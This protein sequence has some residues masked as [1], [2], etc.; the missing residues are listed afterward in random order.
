MEVQPKAQP[1]VA[2]LL[3]F[4]KFLYQQ[5][6]SKKKYL[7]KN[8]EGLLKEIRL[9]FKT[10]EH[11]MAI[12]SKRVDDFLQK[13]YKV[14]ITMFLRGREKAFFNLAKEKLRKFLEMLKGEF[15]IDQPVKKHPV[16]MTIIVRRKK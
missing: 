14:K 15:D 13:G 5:K 8:K 2:K 6:R 12:K 16:G 11:D 4:R 7:A 1:P 9:R 3:D 10:S